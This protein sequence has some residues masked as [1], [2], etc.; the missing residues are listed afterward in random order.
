M[1]KNTII[2]KILLLVVYYKGSWVIRSMKCSR[3][4]NAGRV[5]AS[6]I[7]QNLHFSMQCIHGIHYHSQ[8]K[9]PF[10]TP[11]LAD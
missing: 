5:P 2:V 7:F 10:P 11:Q 8:I 3:M 4:L 1:P 6:V 9:E